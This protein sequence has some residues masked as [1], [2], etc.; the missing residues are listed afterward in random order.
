MVDWNKV[1]ASVL[2]VDVGDEFA[3][4]SFEFRGIR[5]G[6]GSYLNH[7]DVADPLRVILKQ[8]FKRAQ[9]GKGK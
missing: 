1:K 8:L 4:H 7:H 5:Q 2:S 9:L 6:G 3:D